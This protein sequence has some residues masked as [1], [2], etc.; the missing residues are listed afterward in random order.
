M[1]LLLA[2]LLT[3]TFAFCDKAHAGNIILSWGRSASPG[4]AGYNVYYGT[5]SGSYLYKVN[6]GNTGSV[7]ISNL[8]P[9]LTYYFAAS[10]YDAYGHESQLSPQ[11][12]YL[13]GYV[14]AMTGNAFP[15]NQA[16]LQFEV[17][18]GHWYEVQ[19]STD[20]QT[21]TSIWQSIIA[22]SSFLFSFT[23]PDAGSYPS[24]YYRLVIHPTR[25]VTLGTAAKL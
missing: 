12:S 11:I 22:P 4:V 20:L 17:V 10:A 14:L 13:V 25:T 9:G 18:A 8:T 6:T 1:R 19:A 7:T 23:D 3:L 5:T 16:T 2:A 21:W 24:R 15:G